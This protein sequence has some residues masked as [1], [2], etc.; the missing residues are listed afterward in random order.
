MRRPRADLLE[1]VQQPG[2]PLS[3][4]QR[5]LLAVI[6]RATRDLRRR[7]GHAASARAFLEGEGLVLV[8]EALEMEPDTLRWCLV[9]AGELPT[10]WGT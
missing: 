10:Q 3:G 9:A 6:G 4:E 7:N 5:L 1:R 2:Y 8:A